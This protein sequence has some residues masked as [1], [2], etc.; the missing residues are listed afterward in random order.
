MIRSIAAVAA[1]YVV[2]GG[3]AALLFELSGQQAHGPA[4]TA[5]KVGSIIW[6]VVFALIAGWL[7]ARIA[8]R[9]P[10]THAAVLAGL[11]AAGA[12]ISLAFS[13][14]DAATW[15]QVAALVLMAPAAWIGGAAAQRI[16]SID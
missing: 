3:S 2:F 9:R 16:V 12:V 8:I 10:A 5:F 1:G 11:I 13:A 14:R 15:S 4:S 7:T 6:G